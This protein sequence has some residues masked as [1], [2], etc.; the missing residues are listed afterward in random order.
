VWQLTGKTVTW[1]SDELRLSV[2]LLHPELGFQD[3]NYLTDP[4][5]RA[6]LMKV[7]PPPGTTAASLQLDDSYVRENDLVVHYVEPA[8]GVRPEF[9]WRI[10]P[11]GRDAGTGGIA[12]DMLISTRSDLLDSD[13]TLEIQ[14]CVPAGACD[15]L[16]DSVDAARM[17]FPAA[18]PDRSF[19]LDCSC[20]TCALSFRLADA[21]LVFT[22][23]FSTADAVR[24]SLTAGPGKEIITSTISFF[25]GR[26]ERGVMRRVRLRGL[27][28]AAECA[29][30]ALEEQWADMITSPPPLAG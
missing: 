14:S 26:L 30:R 21:P 18:E 29:E 8:G 9:R 4:V 13:P 7:S 1:Q 11:A 16:R 15:V 12:I 24:A 25:P 3:I 28:A 19:D 22:Q 2:D 23:I 10:L 6:S 17:V 20:S 5:P 27:L